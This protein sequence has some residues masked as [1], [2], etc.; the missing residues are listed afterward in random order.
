MTEPQSV[1]ERNAAGD[2]S[3][4]QRVLNELHFYYTEKH[5]CAL[6]QDDPDLFVFARAYRDYHQ[7]PEHEVLPRVRTYYDGFSIQSA[8]PSFVARQ[9]DIL[10]D[11]GKISRVP[12]S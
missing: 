6:A 5:P 7:V 4:N 2:Y 11:A 9:Y 10:V 12:V 3:Y 8:L 1:C